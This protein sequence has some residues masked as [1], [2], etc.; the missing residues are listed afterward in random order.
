M[1][2][3]EYIGARYVPVFAEPAEWDA[4][5]TY[6]PLTVVLYQG[7][8]YTSRQAVPANIPITNTTYWA[9]TGNYNAQVEQYRQEVATFDGRI[10]ELEGTVSPYTSSST[11]QSAIQSEASARISA[12]NEIKNMLSVGSFQGANIMCINDSWGSNNPTYGVEYN[13]MQMVC[14]SLKAN[15]IDLHLGSTGYINSTGTGGQSGNYLQRVQN[16]VADTS[17]NPDSINYIFVMG[18]LN[19]VVYTATEVRT[20][21]TT[22]IDYLYNTFHKAIIVLM[23]Q[24]IGGDPSRISFSSESVQTWAKVARFSYGLGDIPRRRVV[25]FDKL[26]YCIAGDVSAMSSDMVHPNQHGHNMI[27]KAFLTG[28]FGG[29][30]RSPFGV[31]SF[32]DHISINGINYTVDSGDIRGSVYDNVLKLCGIVNIGAGTPNT[33]NALRVYMQDI[34]T[35]NVEPYN[36]QPIG[37]GTLFTRDGTKKFTPISLNFYN[38]DSTSIYSAQK[39]ACSFLNIYKTFMSDVDFSMVTGIQFDATMPLT[40]LS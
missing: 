35:V 3:R 37:M 28:F 13:W 9:Q 19:D 25:F 24:I 14:F 23:P 38:V 2:V 5:R 4:M 36:T 40:Y 34:I 22:L 39:S 8:S 6:E 21:I 20:A 27:A 33:Q 7:N 31:S 1:S 26:L 12:D 30:V 10:D 11:I 32:I 29:S 18:G 17:N 15:Y 16:W